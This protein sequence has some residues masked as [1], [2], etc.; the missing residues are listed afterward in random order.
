MFERGR[1]Y[2]ILFR[3]INSLVLTIDMLVLPIEKVPEEEIF[4]CSLQHKS[5]SFKMDTFG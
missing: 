1:I 5:I 3:S 4:I 2:F